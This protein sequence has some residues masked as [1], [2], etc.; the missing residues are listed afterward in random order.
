MPAF[1][2]NKDDEARWERAKRAARKTLS[3]SDGDSFWKLT[4][5]IYHK[6]LKSLKDIE[7]VESILRKARQ[8][9]SDEPEEDEGDVSPEEAGMREFDPDTEQDD[10][11]KW[12]TENDPEQRQGHEEGEESDVDDEATQSDPSSPTE[13]ES[14]E[15][16]RQQGAAE[17][18]I[19]TGVAQ[20]E[21]TP[22]AQVGTN[23]AKFPQPTREEL[24]D[25][26]QYTRPWEQRARDRVRLEA[27]ASKNPVL[28]HEGRLVEARNLSHKDHQE[29]YAKLQTS[30]EYQGADPVTQMEMDSKFEA[31]WHKQN[32]EY[33]ANA[34]RAHAQAHAEGLRGMGEGAKAK[35]EAIQHVRTGGVQPD[36]PTSTEAAL[37]HAGGVRG[38]EGT[39]GSL[40][41]DPATKFAREH[42]PFL[43]TEGGKHQDRAAARE[44]FYAKKAQEY[45]GK[46]KG[47]P[48]YKRGDIH[49]VLGNHPALK[50]PKSKANVD[51]FFTK[52]HPM[53]SMNAHK[54]L[55]Q[56]GL[57]KNSTDMGALHEAGMHGLFQA[58]ND[59]NH[60]NPGKAT[61]ATHA[62]NKMRGLMQTTLREQQPQAAPLQ[63]EAKK[64][65][66]KQI[67]AKQHP[68]IIDRHKR[69]DTNKKALM[70]KASKEP[71]GGGGGEGGETG[72]QQ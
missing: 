67:M 40:I 5:S 64:Y 54:V 30:P 72:G 57:D 27:E 13:S 62:G 31:D 21:G 7:V 58:I 10:A 33:L 26:R 49:E 68:D 14:P 48:Q 42:Q 59:Y 37:Q 22:P 16:E 47:I 4:N 44:N 34:G 50:D 43:S 55:G 11:D 36:E 46:H 60:D 15:A 29:A 25:M 23:E 69:I 17:G 45:A 32:P 65:N 38:E 61:F 9:L 2:R 19:P 3:E 51:A 63:G 35:K 56:L 6:M 1:I 12:L 52:Y 70:P 24:A 28:A 39:V 71:G 8:R 66:L 20:G 53:I 41:Q 18:D